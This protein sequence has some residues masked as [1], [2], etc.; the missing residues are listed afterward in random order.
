MDLFKIPDKI[1]ILENSFENMNSL[2][3]GSDLS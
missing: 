1:K 3:F 2:N